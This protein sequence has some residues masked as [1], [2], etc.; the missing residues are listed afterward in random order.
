MKRDKFYDTPDKS[1]DQRWGNHEYVK[2]MQVGLDLT[3]EE[4][5]KIKG[6]RRS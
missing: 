6:Y 1:A 3:N 2:Q 5:M 4:A